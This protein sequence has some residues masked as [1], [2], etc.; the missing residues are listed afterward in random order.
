MK[1]IRG[2]TTVEKDCAEQIKNRVAEL[3]IEIK[4]QNTLDNQDIVFIVFSNTSD[5]RSFYP[6]KSAREAG[7]Y[8][9]PLFSALE[10]EIDGALAMCIR[11]L[12]LTELDREVKHIY[13]H[14][15]KNLRSDISKKYNI[16]I[17]GPA[18]SGK[19]TISKI[20]SSKLGIL[21]LDTGAMYRACALKVLNKNIDIA[22]ESRVSDIVKDID[23]SV[24][25]H[26]GGQLTILD[27][28]DVS[29]EIRTAEISMAAST[30]SS[31][32]IVRKKM[33][34]LQR[35]IAQKNSCVLDG[36]DIGTNVLPNAKFKFFL[37][38]SAEVRAKRRHLEDNKLSYEEVL[39]DII[40]RDEQDKN[41]KIAPLKQA[42]DAVLVDTTNLTI[43]EVVALLEKNIQE[44]I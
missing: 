15:A 14:G 29:S 27:G 11:V 32:K 3:L 13:L 18:G 1:A 36:R 30:I 34:E 33:V 20:L 19:S 25:Y 21:C 24:E 22:D 31:Y 7:F 35:I 37:T 2:A 23:L 10:P 44:K 12:V 42:D 9:C 40:K 43:E 41:R 5:I 17:D 39:A 38:A 26:D 16:A 4:E 28:K 8:N 6:A